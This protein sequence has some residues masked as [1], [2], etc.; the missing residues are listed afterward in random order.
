MYSMNLMWVLASRLSSLHIGE[1]VEVA[2]HNRILNQTGKRQR[3]RDNEWIR[4]SSHQKLAQ[5]DQ[6]V[7]GRHFVLLIELGAEDKS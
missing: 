4:T 2:H 6:E 7:E 5:I 1:K 3:W